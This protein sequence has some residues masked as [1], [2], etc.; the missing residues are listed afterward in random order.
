MRSFLRE[1]ARHEE[2]IR[3]T[4]SADPTGLRTRQPNWRRESMTKKTKPR[5]T[6]IRG[7][8]YILYPDLPENGPQPDGDTISFLPDNEDLITGLKR[9]SGRS[10]ERKHLG[11]YNVRFEGIDAL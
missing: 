4:T 9:F 3:V 5:Y 8:Y 1:P 11:T 6:L 2:R 7:D 10:A